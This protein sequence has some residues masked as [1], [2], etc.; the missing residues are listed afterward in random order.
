MPTGATGYHCHRLRHGLLSS[1]VTVCLAPLLADPTREVTVR[2]PHPCRARLPQRDHFARS[3][4]GHALFAGC[5]TPM[6]SGAGPDTDERN[7]R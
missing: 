1:R 4:G 7:R 6:P 5:T 3:D 2:V